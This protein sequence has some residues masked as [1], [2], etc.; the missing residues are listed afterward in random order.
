MSS[1]ENFNYRQGTDDTADDVPK[2]PVS[3]PRAG[4]K[5]FAGYLV[6]WLVLLLVFKK[7]Y[8]SWRASR[9]KNRRNKWFGRHAEREA[10]EEA[11]AAAARNPTPGDEETLRKALL[12]R[13]MT[14]V[15]RFVQ[16]NSEKESLYN[17]MRSGAVSEEM[18]NEFKEAENEMQ[19]ELFD[20][21]AEAETF[22]EGRS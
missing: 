7:I 1:E 15:R 11:V 20:L 5:L 18:W 2:P 8:T 21:Q 12:R 9:L 4:W 10:Y 17:L 22:K 6:V 19:L 3:T 16:L 13:A 14:D